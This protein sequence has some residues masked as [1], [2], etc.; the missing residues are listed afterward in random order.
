MPI[1]I[2]HDPDGPYAEALLCDGFDDA[3]L[4]FGFQFSRPVAIYSRARCIALLV[5]G[6]T[7]NDD[8]PI[9]MSYEEA[10]DYFNVNILGAWVGPHTP[11]FMFDSEE[12]GFMFDS[13]EEENC[14]ARRW[15]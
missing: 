10:E 15:S 7:E 12:E 2:D 14:F 5:D 11:V 6:A 13:E 9:G 3:L 8:A 1:K 4:G